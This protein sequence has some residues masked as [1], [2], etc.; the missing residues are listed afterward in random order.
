MG[1]NQWLPSS[2]DEKTLEVVGHVTRQEASRF[3]KLLYIGRQK[4]NARGAALRSRGDGQWRI[5]EM[6]D[7]SAASRSLCQWSSYGTLQTVCNTV[8][9]KM[10]AAV[11][12][13][14]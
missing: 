7:I 8:F 5:K 2:A 1:L 11:S 3:R 4:R 6:G 12:R 14:F 10:A 13:E 9:F